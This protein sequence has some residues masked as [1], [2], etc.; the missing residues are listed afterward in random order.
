MQNQLPHAFNN[1]SA[2][3]TLEEEEDTFCTY[4]REKNYVT[5]F[6]FRIIKLFI[7]LQDSVFI[8]FLDKIS[9]KL[10]HKKLYVFV[11]FSVFLIRKMQC[12][13]C[14]STL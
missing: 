2:V 13:R 7:I 9:I 12:P 8:F 14:H 11:M 3:P 6:C 4:G 1:E 10:N 5:I